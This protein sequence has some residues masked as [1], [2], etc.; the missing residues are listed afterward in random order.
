MADF[1][2]FFFQRLND[3]EDTPGLLSVPEGGRFYRILTKCEFS[4]PEHT[5]GVFFKLDQEKAWQFVNERSG[6]GKAIFKMV[7]ESGRHTHLEP[8][9]TGFLKDL[10][11]K[12]RLIGDDE[13]Y[14]E[15]EDIA[16][17]ASAMR[18]NAMQ[19]LAQAK[20]DE[21]ATKKIKD[22]LATQRARE[23]D[24]ED[25]REAETTRRLAEAVKLVAE[26]KATQEQVAKDLSESKALMEDAKKLKTE[27]AKR[28]REEDKEPERPSKRPRRGLLFLD[29]TS[30]EARQPVADPLLWEPDARDTDEANK[31]VRAAF[32]KLHRDDDDGSQLARAVD[33]FSVENDRPPPSTFAAI[34]PQL[35]D[36]N[37]KLVSLYEVAR[38]T[39]PVDV[40]HWDPALATGDSSEDASSEEESSKQESESVI[41]C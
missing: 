33:H 37:I 4:H 28:A 15:E 27:L 18:E 38:I 13:E 22:K 40:W 8:R 2:D 7:V 29:V 39:C 21:Y 30:E 25:A 9:I 41:L 5:P 17:P 26:S 20:E 34:L 32:E 11:F 10:G 16:E 31:A 3:D 1:T 24:K 19:Y 23:E 6:G 12:M 36:K 35:V 14:E